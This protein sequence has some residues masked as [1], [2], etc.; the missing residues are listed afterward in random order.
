M[1]KIYKCIKSPGKHKHSGHPSYF[2]NF[3]PIHSITHSQLSSFYFSFSYTLFS[4]PI[5]ANLSIGRSFVFT[6]TTK[7]RDN[8]HSSSH[9]ST[10]SNPEVFT[11]LSTRQNLIGQKP[12]SIMKTSNTSF[13][14]QNLISRKL[15]FSTMNA[16]LC[17]LQ[18]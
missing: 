3:I 4:P 15:S 6:G 8:L 5:F 11:T 10:Q 9:S 16:V 14:K 17:E 12:S 1:I 13:F 2:K 7:P 18:P